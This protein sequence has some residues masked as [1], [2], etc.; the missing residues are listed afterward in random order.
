[1][2]E[3]SFHVNVPDVQQHALRLLHKIWHTGAKVA[4]LA[5]EAQLQAISHALWAHPA[6]AFVP[7][8]WAEDEVRMQ[9]AGCL[10]LT[11]PEQMN[12]VSAQMGVLVQMLDAEQPLPGF[13][14]YA[15][16][17]ELVPAQEAAMAQ[18]RL[19][20]K[21]YKHRAYPLSMHD[22]APKS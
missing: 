3:I 20:W 21:Y 18:A 10:V 13:E 11:R 15:R 17:V 19:R 9:D 4:L 12:A 8:C 2:T 22:F 16:L 1:M 7:H 5:P 14:R 6:T